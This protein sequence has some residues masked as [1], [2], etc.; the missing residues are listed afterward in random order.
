[1]NSSASTASA[2][3]ARSPHPTAHIAIETHRR[4][5]TFRRVDEIARELCDRLLAAAIAN[6]CP[7][8]DPAVWA[9]LTESRS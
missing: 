4:H 9:Q 8:K 7:P 1:M 2:R 5:N 3:S 6:G